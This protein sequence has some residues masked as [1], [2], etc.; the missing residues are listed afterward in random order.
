MI[1]GESQTELDTLKSRVFETIDPQNP[2]EEMLSNRVFEREWFRRRGVRATEDRTSKTIEAIVDGADD[3]DARE[4]DRLAPL[5]EAGDRQAL[6]QLRSF[7]AGVA[8]LRAQWTILQSRLFQDRNLLGTQRLRCFRLAGTDP[9]QALRDE[10]VATKVLRLQIGVMLG[11][12]A[13]LADVASFLGGTPPEWMDQEE[14][15][16]RVNHLRDSLKP[17]KESFLELRG[18]VAEAL[19]ELQAHELKIEQAAA[20]RLEQEVGGAAVD[21]SPEGIRIMNYITN[22]EK[23]FDMALRRIELGRRPD[24]PGPKRAPKKSEAVPAEVAPK[25]ESSPEPATIAADVQEPVAAEVPEDAAAAPTMTQATEIEQD[26]VPGPLTGETGA[27]VSTYEAIEEPAPSETG[28][29]FSTHEAI[30]EPAPAE[31]GAEVS[32]H[33]AIEDATRAETGADVLTGGSGISPPITTAE[34]SLAGASGWYAPPAEAG[35]DFSALE[36]ILD[37][38]GDGA[39]L[40]PD[41]P[42]FVRLRE[43]CCQIEATYCAGRGRDDDPGRDRPPDLARSD[44]PLARAEERLRCRQE[45]LSRQIDA[46]YGL[47]GER[48][49]PVGPERV[50]ERVEEVPP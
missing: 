4:V 35:V 37:D 14:F 15:D 17:K 21:S 48:P 22:N 6:R 29:D 25:A 41:S 40:K 8:Y 18:Y 28:A 36:A 24:R 23:G 3:R 11:P 19:A 46:H 42:E 44:T 5:V 20:R 34:I 7:P 9:L 33:E 50:S 1:A 27:G 12:E 32:T 47:N 16:I 43:L 31:T 10:P 13:D 2:V 45:D 26:D 30:E 39:E 38:M 49:E